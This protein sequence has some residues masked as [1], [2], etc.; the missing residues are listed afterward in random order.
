M[1]VI[2]VGDGKLSKCQLFAVKD[3]LDKILLLFVAVLMNFPGQQK[4]EIAK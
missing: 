2:N 3:H 4:L 1:V